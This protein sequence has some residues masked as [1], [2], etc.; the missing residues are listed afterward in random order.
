M[1][2]LIT[3]GITL[4]SVATT[5]AAWL[6]NSVLAVT[7]MKVL[8]CIALPIALLVL[9]IIAL[10]A[11]F[12]PAECG[13]KMAGALAWYLWPFQF[14]ANANQLAQFIFFCNAGATLWAVVVLFTGMASLSSL[15]IICHLVRKHKTKPNTLKQAMAEEQR[16]Y[17]AAQPANVISV[18]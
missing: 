1:K 11:V 17:A 10:G 13:E 14:L 9:T 2:N 15:A 4:L 12:N 3:I 16:R 6:Y 18:E 7:L 8:V 5:T